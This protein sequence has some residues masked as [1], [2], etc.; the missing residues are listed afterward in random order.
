MLIHLQVRGFFCRNGGCSKKIFSEQVPGLTIR[1]GRR[2]IGLG[3]A[4]RAVALALGG[5]AEA[6]LSRR[7][8]A[9][10]SRMTLLRL[11]RGMPDPAVRRTGAGAGK[12]TTSLCA[13]VTST[14]PC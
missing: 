12:S 2:S 6:R 13:A 7:L 4:L 9:T 11:I 5:R 14:A 10:V 1:Y 8:A 3:K